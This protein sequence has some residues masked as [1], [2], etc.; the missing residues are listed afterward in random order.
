MMFRLSEAAAMLGV[1]FAGA[2]APVLRVS[3]D[4]RSIQ[5]GDLFIALRG[6]KFDGGAYAEDALRQGAAGVVLDHAQA[7]AV[8]QA[9]R[10]AR[11]VERVG[12][13]SDDL[14][15][16]DSHDEPPEFESVLANFYHCRNESAARG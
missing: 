1:P 7:P 11:D 5:P 16:V 10:V 6:E 12:M 8:T 9:I 4:S 3:T 14:L 13:E 2:D 15:Q